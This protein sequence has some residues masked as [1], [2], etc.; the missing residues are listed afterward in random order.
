MKNKIIFF[1]EAHFNQ[2]DY[3][4]FGIAILLNNGFDVQ[5]WN[6][7][8]FL[9]ND[10]YNKIS[11][12]D[13]IK[14]SGYSV[15]KDR[16]EAVKA[17]SG[18][19]HSPL[20]VSFLSY[21]FKSLAV[22]RAISKKRAYYCGQAFALP[23]SAMS[24]KEKAVKKIANFTISKLL[25]RIFYMTPSSILGVRPADFILTIAE[26]FIPPMI[27]VNTKTEKLWVHNFDYDLFLK[28]KDAP[29]A[30][31]KNTGVFLDQYLP[32]HPDSIYSGAVSIV[33]PDEYYSGLCRFFDHLE[34]KFGVKIIIASH[35]RSHYEE[36]PNL[37]GGREIVK[38]K[39]AEL[40]RDAGFVIAHN[41]IAID[42]A[43]L[44]KKP[45]FF[46]TSD[47]INASYKKGLIEEPCV[48]WLA[49]FFG[50]KAHNIDY[51]IRVDFDKEL[52]ID[53]EAYD[54]YKNYYIKKTGSEELPHWQIF[55]D[56]VKRRYVQAQ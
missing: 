37:F 54:R 26:K 53:A 51:P 34:N 45:I 30:V 56:Y 10:A 5:V 17:I 41:S 44:F 9:A 52:G 29:L 42:F 50:K 40:V 39:T 18:L 15:F 22:Y 1:I 14:W 21:N 25:A 27:P 11:P 36:M 3:D 2:R 6:F 4:R 28:A 31:K 12:P 47:K 13:P 16:K 32:F 7:T 19:N 49:S 33:D 55:A 23:I 8:P 43:V 24:S 20:I 38:G 48:M 35:P 46:L